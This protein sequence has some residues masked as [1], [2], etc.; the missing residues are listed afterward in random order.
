MFGYQFVMIDPPWPFELYS[1]KGQAKS[2]EA[3]YRTMSR[4]DIETHR[5]GAFER[6]AA[7]SCR[8][9]TPACLGQLKAR[10]FDHQ[11]GRGQWLPLALF[12]GH[13]RRLKATP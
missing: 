10:P 4:P 13:M 1:V 8:P 3:H 7:F 11:Q 12:D 5:A 2:P 9:G 6:A